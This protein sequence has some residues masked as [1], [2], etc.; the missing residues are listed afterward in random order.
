MVELR[1]NSVVSI[2][3]FC[4]R[5]RNKPEFGTLLQSYCKSDLKGFHGEQCH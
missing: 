4:K 5:L 3:K 2:F 1:G